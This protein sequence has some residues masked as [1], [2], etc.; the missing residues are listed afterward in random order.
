MFLQIVMAICVLLATII[1][2]GVTVM[3]MF[4]MGRGPVTH[5][6]ELSA[7]FRLGISCYFVIGFVIA[8]I[9]EIILWA[10]VY[11]L[12]GALP[13]FEEAAYFSA[14]TYAT[15]GYGDITLSNE[16]R[17]ASALEGVNGILLFG[18]TT[19][20]LFK[21]SELLWFSRS[22]P[23]QTS[24]DRETKVPAVSDKR[25]PLAQASPTPDPN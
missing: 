13:S 6:L 8:H 23:R 3:L 25:Q 2:H 21:V 5:P 9:I 11:R 22:V 7:L 1:I 14:I 18:W 17:L 19:A 12:A 15:I 16:F 24:L 4:R 20:F 10:A